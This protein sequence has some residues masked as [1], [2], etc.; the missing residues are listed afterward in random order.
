MKM[1]VKSVLLPEYSYDERTGRYRDIS[2][3]RFVPATD[4]RA[5]VDTVIAN[6]S[7][8]VLDLAGKLQ[9]GSISLADWQLQ[10]AQRLKTLHVATAIAGR[11]GFASMTSSDYG[12]LGNLIK[13][14]YQY[15]NQF[16]ND[17]ASGK[18]PLN[19]QFVT[20]VNLY[21][22]ATRGT[23]ED[24][25]RWEATNQGNTQERR[26]LG[27]ADHCDSCTSASAKGWQPIGTLPRI[28]ES[29]CK[30]NCKCSFEYKGG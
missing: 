29:L 15:L 19:G 28:G 11:G 9:T 13:A 17:I 20:R 5:A 22:Q 1:P 10:T 21:V 25:K 23:F 8:A 16:A 12:F 7:K 24:V 30:T 18:Q 6:N 26:I 4:I 27:V 2:T 3:G 14:Q